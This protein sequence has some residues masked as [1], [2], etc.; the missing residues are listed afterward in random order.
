VPDTT[1][2]ALTGFEPQI[3]GILTPR[4]ATLAD[5]PIETL[6]SFGQALVSHRQAELVS[7]ALSVTQL[8]AT[9]SPSPAAEP[10][11]PGSAGSSAGT[12]SAGART[13]VTP[14]PA[15]ASGISAQVGPPGT[16]GQIPQVAPGL[17]PQLA[18]AS[19]ATSM[20]AA[21]LAEAPAVGVSS[22]A[23]QVVQQMAVA[24]SLV[25][26]AQGA[27]NAFTSAVKITPIGM[28]HLE[29][30]EMSPAGIER[31]ELL[32]TIP[33]AP[34]ET[35]SVEQHEWTVTNE[36]L[37]SIVTDY[38]ENYSEKG[39]TEKT[40]L[41]EASS[42]ET[43]H[44]QQMGLDASLSGSYGFVTFSTNAKFQNNLST[45]Q[46]QK[47]SRNNT[48]EVTTK[49]SSRVRK[50]R[51][52]TIQTSTTTGQSE[53]TTRT[54]T[55]PSATDSMRIDYYSMMRRWEVRL[56]QYGL[57][58]T[59]DI[60]IPEPGSALRQKLADLD[61][62]QKKASAE[63]IFNVPQSY[64]NEAN[65]LQYAASYQAQV[66]SPPPAT[67]V[68]VVGG[69]VTGLTGDDGDKNWRINNVPF[70]VPPGYAIQDVTVDYQEDNPFMGNNTPFQTTFMVLGLPTAL[71]LQRNQD[72][73]LDQ[74][75]GHRDLTAEFGYMQGLTDHQEITFT[76]AYCHTAAANFTITSALT[77]A[78]REEWRSQVWSALY[79]AAQAA[80]Y[81]EQQ[82]VNGQITALTD[83][84]NAADTLTLRQEELAEVMKGVLRW[85]LGPAFEFMP[86]EVIDLFT[87]RGLDLA[88]GLLYVDDNTLGVDS[89]GWMTMFQYQ[90]MV[91][92]LHEAI[93]WENLIYF[94]YP[95]FWDIPASWDFV[96]GIQHPDPSR[97]QFLRSGSARVVLTVRPG[98]EDSFA[99]FVDRGDFGDILPPDHP[100]ISIGQQIAAY[101]NTNYPG[102]AP[103]NPAQDYRPLL[104]PLQRQAW[105]DIQAIMA[106]LV[107]YQTAHGT[108][109]T[110][111]QGLTALAGLGT[112]PSADPWGK[113]YVYQCPG[114]Y[115]DYDLSSNGADGVPGGDG[116][117][118]DIT[119]WATASLIG[120]WYEYTPSHGT[121]IQV[122]TAP[123]DMA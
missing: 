79:N 67:T 70:D 62:L 31:G 27:V 81:A 49:A 56:L 112:V 96:R 104:T 3:V 116:D 69:P 76:V 84:L 15:P 37:S 118:A 119:S 16:T 34:M 24:S 75:T 42:S 80:Y 46:S 63:F 59:Y 114:V 41:A 93:E 61:V 98:F 115:D 58:L 55:N 77:D 12:T 94:L 22:R 123:A 2:S 111:A 91:K 11:A 89:T 92:F 100:Y 85:L 53:T 4:P 36:E 87:G 99:A 117:N 121:D 78:G 13:A 9:T 43:K 60:A 83:A 54:L 19:T 103:A 32:A 20:S 74:D 97:Q 10:P 90:E 26:A 33:L 52:V 44:D 29:R 5:I 25:T 107:Q 106:L 17:S 64:I 35:T 122:N 88:H 65:Y 120:I 66:P 101:S 7:A 38:L 8:P 82:A 1:W 51:K 48:K 68:Q 39:V 109:P 18:A 113:P 105:S 30:V 14:G 45:D 6:A 28:L 110:T 73:S 95:Y 40:E 50:E 72:G 71:D 57:R 21:A 47:D 102:V 86:Q 23:L 108:Y